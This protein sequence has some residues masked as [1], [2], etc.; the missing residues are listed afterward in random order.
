MRPSK[1]ELIR[2]SSQQFVDAFVFILNVNHRSRRS[3]R[4]YVFVGFKKVYSQDKGSTHVSNSNRLSSK[5]SHMGVWFHTLGNHF[6]TP[7]PTYKAKIMN[8]NMAVNC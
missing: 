2:L 8:K 6:E 7:I 5:Y 3:S 1:R 4:I